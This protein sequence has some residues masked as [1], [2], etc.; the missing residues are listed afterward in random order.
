MSRAD[1]PRWWRPAQYAVAEAAAVAMVATGH[2]GAFAWFV[3][4]VVAG[5]F[6]FVGTPAG[7]RVLQDTAVGN[8]PP[9]RRLRE[10]GDA[11]LGSYLRFAVSPQELAAERE[12]LGLL[13]YQAVK[14]RLAYEQL[15]A[16]VAE[17]EDRARRTVR[18]RE[19]RRPEH[20]R[21]VAGGE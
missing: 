11:A 5:L 14:D 8:H 9:V 1:R 20:H 18:Y 6:V 2:L 10:R 16:H 4:N 19:L 12:T 15:E 21:R 3:G 7:E 13:A 17:L